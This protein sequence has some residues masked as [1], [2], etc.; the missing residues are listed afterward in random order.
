MRIRIAALFFSSIA[1]TAPRAWAQAP[2]PLP[3]GAPGVA[4]PGAPPG[5]PGVTAAPSAP[6]GLQAYPPPAWPPPGPLQT[7][8][9]APPPPMQPP[10]SPP[11]APPPPEAL[12]IRVAGRVGFGIGAYVAPGGGSGAATAA[13][14]LGGLGGILPYGA[15][16]GIRWWAKERLAVLPSLN[17]TILHTSAPLTTTASGTIVPAGDFTE[18]SIAPGLSL[19]YA[20]YRGKTTRFLVIGGASFSYSAQARVKQDANPGGSVTTHYVTAKTLGFNIPFGFALEQF[21]TSRISVVVGA[22]APL[23]EFLSTKVGFSDASTTVGANFNAT[24][25]GASLYFYT[26]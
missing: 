21:F 20:A 9:F 7:P 23:F 19:G 25:L 18:G 24:Q 6:P 4:G 16:L 11:Q 13:A 26:D 17:L 12:P 2:S 15:S 14:S 10:A 3:P 22:Q 8:A 5:P 1:L